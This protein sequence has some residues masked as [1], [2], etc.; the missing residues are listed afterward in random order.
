MR[1]SRYLVPVL[2]AFLLPVAPAEAAETAAFRRWGVTQRLNLDSRTETLLARAYALVYARDFG[3]A[4]QC[5]EIA[6]PEHPDC[7][8]AFTGLSFAR[9]YQSDDAGAF[10]AARAALKLDSLSFGANWNFGELLWP[11]RGAELPDSLSDSERV[12]LSIRHLQRAL[13]SQ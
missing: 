13:S 12:A 6:L 8:E 9:R 3:T 7:A 4:A 11:W 10:Q 5:Y 1:A 2:L